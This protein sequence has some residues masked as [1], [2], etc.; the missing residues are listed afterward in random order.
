MRSKNPMTQLY[1]YDF[2]VM[3]I[4]SMLSKNFAT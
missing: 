1:T 3:V 4:G 2:Y